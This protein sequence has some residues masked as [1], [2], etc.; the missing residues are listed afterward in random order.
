VYFKTKSQWTVWARDFFVLACYR[1]LDDVDFKSGYLMCASSAE[2]E[3]L[4]PLDSS[5]VRGNVFQ[6]GFVLEPTE[7]GTGT[8]VTYIFRSRFLG[9]G[10][11]YGAGRVVFS[12]MKACAHVFSLLCLS[13]VGLFDGVGVCPCSLCMCVCVP[14]CVCVCLAYV[15][16]VVCVPVCWLVCVN[17]RLHV[18]VVVYIL[19]PR[20]LF[21]YRCV[22]KLMAVGGFLR[23]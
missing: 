6:S 14:V 9:G 16:Y 23:A 21:L 1:P 13:S 22:S 17:V 18:C 10:V 12:W 2:N 15:L 4:A 20:I 11:C 19:F 7:D 3:S 5:C 8:S